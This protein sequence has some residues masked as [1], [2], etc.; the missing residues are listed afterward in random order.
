MTFEEY[1]EQYKRSERRYMNYN[2][3]MATIGNGKKQFY[4]GNKSDWYK[5]ITENCKKKS[6]PAGMP[7]NRFRK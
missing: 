7:N 3:I 4:T 5:K 2:Q 1:R 6:F